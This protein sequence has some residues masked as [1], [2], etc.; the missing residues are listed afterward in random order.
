MGAGQH[1]DDTWQTRASGCAAVEG[2]RHGPGGLAID[3]VADKLPH[4]SP[5]DVGR[6]AGGRLRAPTGQFENAHTQG[7]HH[8]N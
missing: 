6:S 2:R 7:T 1:A 4:V 3:G 5:A 8:G